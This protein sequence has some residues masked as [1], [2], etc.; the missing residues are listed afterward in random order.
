MNTYCNK[1][2]VYTYS[3]ITICALAIRI[4]VKHHIGLIMSFIFWRFANTIHYNKD[5]SSWTANHEDKPTYNG[6]KNNHCH[7]MGRERGR[8]KKREGGGRREEERVYDQYGNV[9]IILLWLRSYCGISYSY[10]L[11]HAIIANSSV[12]SSTNL[13]VH[14]FQGSLFHQIHRHT[15]G[16][17]C[18]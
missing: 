18:I 15:H 8:E 3:I 2:E 14:Y 10:H 9:N 5:N 11:T 12:A 1:W 6:A 13:E 17:Y 4:V 16:F 7:C